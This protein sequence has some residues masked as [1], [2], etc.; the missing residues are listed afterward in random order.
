MSSNGDFSTRCPRSM[1]TNKRWRLYKWRMSFKKVQCWYLYRKSSRLWAQQ[2]WNYSAYFS[3]IWQRPSVTAS[4]MSISSSVFCVSLRWAAVLP[5]A[6]LLLSRPYDNGHAL[7]EQASRSPSNIPIR[8]W[9]PSHA[10]ALAV[11]VWCSKETSF[12]QNCPRYY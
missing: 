11:E 3:I 9:C 6:T 5:G 8:L 7:L 4:Q 1:I 12:G 2:S 10:H